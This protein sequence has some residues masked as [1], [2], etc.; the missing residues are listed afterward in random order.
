MT[1]LALNVCYKPH[2]EGL[3]HINSY[4]KSNLEV[5]RLLSNFAEI[6]LDSRYG[7]FSNIEAYWAYLVTGSTGIDE[8]TSPLQ[9]RIIMATETSDQEMQC[10]SEEFPILIRDAIRHKLNANKEFLLND[11]YFNN[12]QLPITHYWVYNGKVVDL[13][14]RKSTTILLDSI[15]EWR[16]EKLIWGI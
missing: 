13:S 12:I 5:G 9:A 1:L 3:T 8:Y 4:S 6:E 2:E 15:D 10:S 11:E 7:K 14:K 16:N